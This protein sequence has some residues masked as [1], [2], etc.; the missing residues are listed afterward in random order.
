MGYII[1]HVFGY[2][3][4]H[5]VAVHT[6][7]CNDQGEVDLAVQQKP[8]KIVDQNLGLTCPHLHEIAVGVFEHPSIEGLDLVV[9]WFRL[10]E[11]C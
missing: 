7:W 3:L 11:V 10:K 9:V 8:R 1:G 2:F 5:P 4:G 6:L